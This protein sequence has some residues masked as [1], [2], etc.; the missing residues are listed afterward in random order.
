[1]DDVAQAVALIEIDTSY[2][3]FADMLGKLKS[4]IY[5]NVRRWRQMGEYVSRRGQ[6]RKRSTT[7]RDDRF[8]V[9]NG[10]KTVRKLEEEQ[11]LGPLAEGLRKLVWRP[12]EPRKLH[13]SS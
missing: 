8:I 13:Y 6:G 9:L 1:M 3:D 7:A 4:T 12:I 2:S 5:R 10:H 11:M